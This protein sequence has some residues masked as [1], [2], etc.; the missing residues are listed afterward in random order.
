MKELDIE[1]IC[2]NTPQAKGRVER[3]NK[4]LQ[5]RLTKELRLQN[6]STPEEANQ[7]LPTFMEEYNRRFSTV[8]RSDIDSHVPLSDSNNLDFIL[9]RKETR[10]LSKNLTF[11][12]YKKIY[13][14][15][16]DRP[17]YALRNADVTVLEKPNHEIIVLYKNQPIHFDIY[18]QQQKQAEVVPSKSIDHALSNASK[19]QKPAPCLLYT[20]D[21]ADD[22]LCVALGGRRII[23]KKKHHH[24]LTT[25]P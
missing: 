7:W 5:D 17:S 19:A 13:Q 10:V 9:C 11:Q 8:P 22:L 23:K 3:A 20:S 14:I 4:T 2:A 18:I 25:T 21:A 16:E 6:I 12:Y 15:H 1:M 24:T